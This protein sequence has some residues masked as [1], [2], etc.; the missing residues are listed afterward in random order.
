MNTIKKLLVLVMFSAASLVSNASADSSNF[1]GPYVGVAVSMAGVELDG[2][3]TDPDQGVSTTTN[4]STGMIG[5]FGS[6]Q[7]GY[8]APMNEQAFMTIGLSYTPTGEADFSAK[9][10]ASNKN[11]KFELSDL[12]EVFVEPSF[13]VTTNSALFV[14][15]GY[16]EADLTA[17]GTDVTNKTMAL[18]GTTISGGLKVVTDNNIFIKAEAG[19]SDYGGFTLDK[20]VG[21]DGNATAK[22]SGDAEVAFGQLTIGKKF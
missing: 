2:K 22:A 1:A 16:V 11:V 7:A 8:N 14:H 10:L 20:I 18:D 17:T 3:Y 21:V 13:M 4:G 5:M 12:I 9:N 6:L 19:M 15:L